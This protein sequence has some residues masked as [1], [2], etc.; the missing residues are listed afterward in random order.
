MRCID[1][2]C[3]SA[4]HAAVRKTSDWLYKKILPPLSGEQLMKQ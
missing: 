4:T 1:G 3:I 2:M